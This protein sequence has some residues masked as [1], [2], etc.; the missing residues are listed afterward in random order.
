LKI[1]ITG[2]GELGS[3][4]A[5]T[6]V[7]SKIDVTVIDKDPDVL[8]RLNEH[9]D[10]LTLK[11]HGAKIEELEKIKIK[12]YDLLIA[13][14][15]DDD[16]NILICTVAK[17][18]GCKKVIAR[19]RN[20]LY[21]NQ[22]DFFRDE[23]G[24]DYIVNPELALSN[25]IT[26]YI[27]ENYTFYSGEFADGRISIIDMNI[28]DLPTLIGKRLMDLSSMR[29]L[30][31]VAIAR[32]DKTIIPYGGTELLENDR[33]YIIGKKENISTLAGKR[34]NAADK[35]SVKKAMILG[36]GKTGFYTADKLSKFGISVKIIEENKERCE[37][38]SENLEDALV[39]HG[40]GSD[41]DLLE[42]EDLETMDAFIGVTGNDEENLFMSLRAKQL[43]VNKIIA[44][45]KQQSYIHITE[46]LGID[47]VISPS[48]ITAS[49]IIKYIRG[50]K[51]L[52]VSLLL[53]GQAEVTE[54]IVT[55]D[56]PHIGKTLAEMKMP[57][58]FIVGAVLHNHETIIPKGDTVINVS[59]RL[60]I[61][62]LITEI[63]ALEKFFKLK[64]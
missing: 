2:A 63:P 44:K 29:N 49:E 26:R 9:L 42:E 3:K 50:G 53:G 35:T 40:D 27:V 25:E 33:I 1:I 64:K 34:K 28:S 48:D 15:G 18:L 20:P 62:C 23:L 57:R 12:T 10:V 55:S 22:L 19:I 38:L 36:G 7:S 51:V 30:I 52:S 5:N 6:L 13:V 45:V 4:L 11:A 14:T 58:G 32:D 24:I 41:I 54:I 8:D 16:T 47:A 43:N 46:K 59:D 37:Y 39:I 21:S 61:F 56:F 17:K 60:V 31:I